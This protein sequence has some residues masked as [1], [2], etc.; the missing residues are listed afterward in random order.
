MRNQKLSVVDRMSEVQ[1]LPRE[2]FPLTVKEFLAAKQDLASRGQSLDFTFDYIQWLCE[3][4]RA[5]CGELLEFS[6]QSC[7]GPL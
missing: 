6:V 5:N 2:L 3:G 1:T 7:Q 4:D